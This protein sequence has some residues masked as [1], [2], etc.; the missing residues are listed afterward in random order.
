MHTLLSPAAVRPVV[1]LA[2]HCTGY[3]TLPSPCGPSDRVM[4]PEPGTVPCTCPPDRGT[5]LIRVVYRPMTVGVIGRADVPR[6]PGIHISLFVPRLAA[7]GWNVPAGQFLGNLMM[8]SPRA[9][10]TG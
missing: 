10:R 3:Q 9:G 5:L 8:R 4:L 7:G 6:H 2:V 1:V